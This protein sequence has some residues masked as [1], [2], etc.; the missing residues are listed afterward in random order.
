MKKI[1]SEDLIDDLLSAG[2][3]QEAESLFSRA[4]LVIKLRRKM[5]GVTTFKRGRPRK[6]AEKPQEAQS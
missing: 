6:S 4:E 5:Q 1:T 3:L 2:T